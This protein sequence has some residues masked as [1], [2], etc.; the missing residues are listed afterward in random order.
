[1]NSVTDSETPEEYLVDTFSE[2]FQYGFSLRKLS[3][4]DHE[5]T[6][7]KGMRCVAKGGKKPCEVYEESP[8]KTNPP[9]PHF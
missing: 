4:A 9:S 1:M 7:V 5:C 2:G 6:C 8:K 3:K